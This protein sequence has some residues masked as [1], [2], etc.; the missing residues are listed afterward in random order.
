M[1]DVLPVDAVVDLGRL[2]GLHN[3]VNGKDT[4]VLVYHRRSEVEEEEGWRLST[5]SDYAPQHT[6]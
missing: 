5:G 1:G 4:S 2:A 3:H 6:H